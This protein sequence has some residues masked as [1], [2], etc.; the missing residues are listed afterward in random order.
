MQS[1]LHEF[2]NRCCKSRLYLSENELNS[3]GFRTNN[4]LSMILS[5][6]LQRVHAM[7]MHEILC[8]KVLIFLKID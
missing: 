6:G 5:D 7:F 8:A 2:A 3:G 1:A 4:A